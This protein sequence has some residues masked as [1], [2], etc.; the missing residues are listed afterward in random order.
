M[1]SFLNDIN[2]FHV[3][4]EHV[5]AALDGATARSV[6]EGN[7]GGGTGMKCHLFKGGIGTAS[8]KT[9]AGYT[10][11]VLLQANH[12]TRSR[13]TVAGVPV[14]RPRDTRFVAL[15]RFLSRESAAERVFG[16]RDEL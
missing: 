9:K 7:V 14:G 6:A 12:G 3:K 13:L 10:V 1:R 5:A 15:Q 4:P 2:G 11:G 16:D 8:R